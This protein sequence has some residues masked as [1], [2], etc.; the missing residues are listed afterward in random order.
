MVNIDLFWNRD[1]RY[2]KK[3]GWKGTQNLDGG[4]LFTQFSHFIDIMYWLF[5]DID[6]IQARLHDFNHAHSTEFED[7]GIVMFDL[8]EGGMGSINFSTAVSTVNYESSLTVI[9]EKGT[10]KIGGQYMNEVAYC[11]IENYTMPELAEGNPANDYGH[12]KG[13]AANHVYIIQ[14]VV[15]AIR[16]VSNITTNALEGLKVVEI[17]ERIYSAAKTN[18]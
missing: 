14:N 6:N 13:S 15:D 10:V 17:I 7:S 3:G 11:Q 12:Y 5:G 18:G 9:A 16:G 8:V 4:T 1:D 2:Y